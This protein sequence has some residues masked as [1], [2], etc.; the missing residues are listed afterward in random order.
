M[1]ELLLYPICQNTTQI[2][3]VQMINGA[4]LGLVLGNAINYMS[5]LAPKG[6]EASAMALYGSVGSV[7]GIITNLFA[8]AMLDAIGIRNFFLVFGCIVLFA[9]LFFLGSYAF[10][11]KVLKKPAPVPLGFARRTT[12]KEEEKTE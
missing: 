11:T 4:A 7:A 2:L 6:L 5:I 9:V 12:Q 3:L 1:I 8:S 10:G